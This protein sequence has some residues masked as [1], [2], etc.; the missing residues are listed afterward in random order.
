MSKLA[1]Y[2]VIFSL[3]LAQLAYIKAITEEESDG[4]LDMKSMPAKEE[5][6]DSQK[7]K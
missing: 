1:S 2:G 6:K 7:D 3:L 4:V 5:E